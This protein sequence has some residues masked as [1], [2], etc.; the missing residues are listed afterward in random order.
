MSFSDDSRNG[1]FWK[2][3]DLSGIPHKNC[4]APCV[5]LQT[6]EEY[7]EYVKEVREIL[8]GNTRDICN[9][10]LEQME[11][12]SEEMKFEE[13]MELKKNTTWL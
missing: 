3:S 4:K 1:G 5:G 2:I 7:M 9:R 6:R 13:A 11:K 10:M 12:L 8:R